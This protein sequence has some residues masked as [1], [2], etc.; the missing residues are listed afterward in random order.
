MRFL[1]VAIICA[2]A[3]SCESDSG[4]NLQSGT[5]QAGSMTRFAIAGNHLY[6]L[7]GQ[8]IKVFNIGAGAFSQLHEEP[9]SPG[10]ETIFA[11]GNYLY[12]GAN[13]G[14][15]IYSTENPERPSFVFRYEHIVACDPVVVQG[16]RA[17]ITTRGGNGCNRGMNALEIVDISDP[18]SPVLVKNY[19]MLSPHGLAVEGN[20]LFVCEGE[21]GLKVFDIT[22]ENAITLTENKEDFFAYDV[23]A[24]QGIATVTGSDGIF[25]FSYRAVPS[26]L[27]LLSK[28]PVSRTK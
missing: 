17:Y 2:L 22:N 7:E 24:R 14:M 15:Y 8:Y 19:P 25:Q 13:D 18:Y 6:L 20:I 3:I 5:G 21:F 9:V 16:N 4:L 12:L 11:T 27:T 28:I 10:I 1:R 26:S 23:I